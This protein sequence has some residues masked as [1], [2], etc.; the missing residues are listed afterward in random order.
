M[1]PIKEPTESAPVV[2]TPEGWI[3][4]RVRI[5]PFTLPPYASPQIQLVLVALVC[6]LC[7]GMYN[8]LSGLGGGG[9]VSAKPADNA[10]SALYSTFSVVGFFAGTFAN[11]LGVKLTL[12][13]GGLGY[14][15][16]ASSYLCY[17]HTQNTG[18]VIFAGALLGVCAGLLWTAQGA[19]MMSYP[20]EESKGK[21][22]SWFWSIFN[23][24][25][26]VGALIPLALNIDVTANT[27][28]SD[29]TYIGFIILMFVGALSALC[30]CDANKVRRADGSHV[31]LMKNPTW[32]T[33][34]WGLWYTLRNNVYVFL[35][36]PMFFA[37]NWFY[38]YQF[39]GVNGAHF[40]TR[41]RALNNILYWLA[42]ILGAFLSGYSLDVQRYTRATRARAG[43][44]VLL[45]LTF[46]IWGA[47]YAWQMT[48]P[49]RNITGK[50]NYQDKMD[51]KDEG[52]PQGLAMYV[53]YGFY[54]AVWQ[55]SVYW[56]MGA[57][58]NSGRKTAN[59]AGFYKGIQSAGA[60]ISWRIDAMDYSYATQFAITWALLAGSLVI[61]SPVIFMK[62]KDA[63]D[64][65]DDLVDTDLNYADVMPQALIIDK[66]DQFL[67]Q[68]YQNNSAYPRHAYNSNMDD[69]ETPSTSPREDF[70]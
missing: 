44:I 51:W 2:A 27:V 62:I 46:A 33:E 28:V 6:F 34:I 47:G 22:I 58:S 25:G 57:L 7:V 11:R 67:R 9:Q 56:F 49:D 50:P 36:F 31:I 17:S 69:I 64:I 35:L 41:T 53:A 55:L 24:G 37:S 60:A 59:F 14:C 26:V 30:L 52:Y 42:Q 65:D 13:L 32:N 18:Y 5:G 61:A 1:S 54:D 66:N 19:I 48:V 43:L 15:V 23:L 12:S 40:N 39:N 70:R 3:Y 63:T 45:L 21:Y 8:A 16:Y 68:G 10:N 38:T 4:K 29:G 20:P